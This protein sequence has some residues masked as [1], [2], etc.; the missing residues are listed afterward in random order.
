MGKETL[1]RYE[2]VGELAQYRVGTVIKATDPK[3]KQTV[4]LKTFRL[5]SN[6]GHDQD[7]LKRFRTE[8]EEARALSS[9]N[10]V[11]VLG[12]GED[13]GV[14][15]AVLEFVDGI[16]IFDMMLSKKDMS[17][18]DVVDI[19]RQVCS[20]LDHAASKKIVHRNLKPANVMVEWDGSVKIMDYGVP[21]GVEVGAPGPNTI[22]QLLYYMA[23]EQI[24]R[25]AVDVRSNIFNW[26]AILYELISGKKAAAGESREEVC[27]SILSQLPPPLSR[28]VPGVPPGI[29]R[30]VMK[31]L[32]KN[33]SERYQTGAELIN[34]IE[35]YKQ[36]GAAS[37]PTGLDTARMQA[38]SAPPNI[39]RPETFSPPIAV[40]PITPPPIRTAAP[41]SAYAANPVTSDMMTPRP[42]MPPAPPSYGSFT[43]SVTPIPMTPIPL[44]PKQAAPGQSSV[45]VAPEPI[46]GTVEAQQSKQESKVVHP[47]VVAAPRNRPVLDSTIRISTPP[48]VPERPAP[49]ISAPPVASAHVPAT[50]PKPKAK[51]KNA[52]FDLADRKNQMIAGGAV[53][54]LLIIAVLLGLQFGHNREEVIQPTAANTLPANPAPVVAAPAQLPA[55]SPDVLAAEQQNSEPEVVYSGKDKK[56]KKTAV[57]PVVAA[58][59]TPITGQL[60]INSVPA[61][62]QVQID[63]RSDPGWVTPYAVTLYAGPHSI[64]LTKPGFTTQSQNVEVVPSNRSVVSL[65]LSEMLAIAAI[66]S[67]PAGSSI[68]VDGRDTGKVTP[69]QLSIPK[70]SHTVTV[71]R[72]GYFDASQSVDL[73]PGQ[74]AHISPSLKAMGDANEVR[75]TNKLGKLFGGGA[76]DVGVVK[77]K[78]TPKGAQITINNRMM[79]RGT[80]AEFAIPPGNYEIVLTAPGYKPLQKMITLQSGD[81]LNLDEVLEK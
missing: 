30:V 72:L 5:D 71:R 65:N 81:R 6:E 8:V 53:L 7:L 17:T 24:Q 10:I 64:V 79:D 42:E 11:T 18:N 49:K 69:A 45:A 31:A 70:G 73:Y 38:Q 15:F 48:A 52:G 41:T 66:N 27:K 1:G 29:N 54:L 9:P 59:P 75:S 12:S 3:T 55:Q 28:V 67:D 13:K 34:D 51:S 63:G 56:K 77:I 22:P 36:F 2:V 62:A 60:A 43:P 26:G 37:V 23:P 44:A 21:P 25:A 32:A 14:F 33:P 57:K 20:A 68:Y 50:L 39:A 47:L 40:K 58:A 16:R 76:K 46:P 80:P 4:A 78:T 74:T 35:H 19:S 61:G